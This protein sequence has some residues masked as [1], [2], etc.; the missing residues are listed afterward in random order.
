MEIIPQV[1]DFVVNIDKHLLWIMQNYGT[2]AYLILFLIIFCETGL[3]VTP[4]LPGDSLLFVIGALGVTGTVDFKTVV[5]FLIIAAVGGNTL[6]YFIGKM[7]GH[8]ILE[9]TKFPFIHRIIKKEYIERAYSFYDKHGRKAI[10][11][12]R[13][14]P[15]VG[16]SKK[17]CVN[18]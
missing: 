11:L 12:S 4:F 14:L 7:I 15:I 10:L 17:L 1:M 5:V 18:W 9:S 2:W 3:V 8:R 13:F 16:G 6:N